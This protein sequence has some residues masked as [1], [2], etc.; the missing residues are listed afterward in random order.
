[1]MKPVWVWIMQVME[2]EATACFHRELR[3]QVVPQTFPN[4]RLGSWDFTLPL[5]PPSHPSTNTQLMSPSPCIRASKDKSKV[6]LEEKDTT[7]QENANSDN[8]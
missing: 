3:I 4:P 2:R 6:T 8:V 5:S 7:A 1:M